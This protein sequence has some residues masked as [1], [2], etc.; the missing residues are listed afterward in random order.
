MI[1]LQLGCL[2]IIALI[3]MLY[4]S[5]HRKHGYFHNLFSVLLGVTAV[6]IGINIATVYVLEASHKVHPILLKTVFFLYYANLVALI[7][8]T[9][10]YVVS[11]VK[12][13]YQ[14]S[15]I[16]GYRWCI[17]VAVAVLCLVVIPF[18]VKPFPGGA[19]VFS[20]AVVIAYL[21]IIF[22]ILVLLCLFIRYWKLINQKK[23]QI[24][25]VVYLVMASCILSQTFHHTA[26]ISA[27][28]VTLLVAGLYLSEESPDVKLIQQLQVEK[29]RA[30]AANNAKSAFLANMSHEM[31]TPINAI[32]GMDEMIL[33]ESREDET[34]EHAIDI[35]NAAQILHSLINDTLDLSKIES[36]KMEI[37]PVEYQL[38]SLINDLVNMTS[39]RAD[40]KNLK[41]IVEVD[42][43]L[44]SAYFGDD[45]RIRQVLTNILTNAVK[46]TSEG[47]VT[48]TVKRSLVQDGLAVLHFSVADTGEGIREEDMPKLFAAFERIEEGRHRK[49]EGTG[50][51]MSITTKL[52]E[53]MGTRLQVESEYGKGSNFYFD[54]EQ[55]IL[56]PQPIGN[57]H[58]NIRK[59]AKD[60][61][62]SASFV[63]PDAKVLVVDDNEINRKVF[64]GLLKQTKVQVTEAASGKACLELVGQQHFDLI[65]LDHMM[66][67]MDG[68][69]TM[70][71]MKEMPEEENRCVGTPVIILT[72]N[73]VTGVREE[74]LQM[75]FDEYLAKPIV[76]DKLEAMIQ[77]MLP[78][79]LV[80]GGQDT[81]GEQ[82]GGERSADAQSGG[83]EPA[84]PGLPETEGVDWNYA[85]LHL[86]DD[87]LI[88]STAEEFRRRLEKEDALVENLAADLDS[89]EGLKNYRIEVHA[90]KS[91]AA[92][93][94]AM[95]LSALAALCER[96]AIDGD[97]ERIRL[98]TPLLLEQIG[99]YRDRF[100]PFARQQAGEKDI[101]DRTEI[102][103]LLDMVET[104]MQQLDFDKADEAMASLREYRFEGESGQLMDQLEGYVESLD[105]QAAEQTAKKLAG[106]L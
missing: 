84:G 98:L 86:P 14:E 62:Y 3:A 66:P 64:I 75:G 6:Y 24:I 40:A 16:K 21:A 29:A 25:F 88:R 87:D 103:A 9:F 39:V 92:M 95:Q 35:K 49:E 101:S 54:L 37:V 53:L 20:P 50:L 74:Y 43:G 70:Q 45:V 51:G 67:E 105:A 55:R 56:N 79:G 83:Q 22:Y 36:G 47:S 13:N 60:Y 59:M 42:P 61:S 4:Y 99:I 8:V 82:A 17:P 100:A 10:L 38:S 89:Q 28:A 44:P 85:K 106:L 72:A 5:A 57:F 52:L 41:L 58:E 63:A 71:R 34:R 2:G 73:A 94:G 90:L 1:S 97:R 76:P 80:R 27:F 77:R 12:E 26:A 104:S 19:Y 96:S 91:S 81:K 65:F 68:I 30:D 46:Y 7:Y 69:E 11:M 15:R 93:I 33:R 48:L 78:A 23:R 18:E 32:I 102:M 31:R